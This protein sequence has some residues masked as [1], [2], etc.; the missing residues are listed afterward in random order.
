[1]YNDLQTPVLPSAVTLRW[2]TMRHPEQQQQVAEN[3]SALYKT[4]NF[5]ALKPKVDQDRSEYVEME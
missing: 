5:T 3:N 4:S 1:M 2:I